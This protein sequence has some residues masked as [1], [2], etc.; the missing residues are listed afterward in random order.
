MIGVRRRYAV[1]AVG[2][3]T[4]AALA[5]RYSGSMVAVK[6]T[7]PRPDLVIADLNEGQITLRPLYSDLESVWDRPGVWIFDSGDRYD[8]IG[9]V[10]SSTG[11]TV[12]REFIPITGHP[13]V[14]DTG[15]LAIYPFRGDPKSLYGIDFE[16]HSYPT[17]LGNLPAWY[18]AGSKKTWA[19]YVH[20]R[21]GSRAETLRV[22]PPVHAAGYPSLIITYRNDAEAPPS[23]NRYFRY[24]GGEWED[25]EDAVEYALA[26][27]AEDVILVGY[28]MGGSV[29][30]NFLYESTLSDR[31]TAAILD[32]PVLDLEAVFDHGGA[33]RGIPKPVTAIGKAVAKARFG[34]SWKR[35]NL[36]NRVYK[37][38]AR[39][40]LFH[41]DADRTV[42]IRLSDRFAEALGD[43]ATYVRVPGADHVRCWNMDPDAYEAHISAFLATLDN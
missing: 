4:A 7:R 35:R 25:V 31:V 16:H 41:G 1:P 38:G 32:G 19:I 43:L 27:G 8:R 20:G 28:S 5:W 39:I 13:S 11:D 2:F 17:Q 40:L 29:V 34:I 14:G 3:A 36:L 24:G 37:I 10:I 21:R 42:P 15:H 30:V 9:R 23:P 26:H 18:V 12:T 22:L 6:Q 33:R